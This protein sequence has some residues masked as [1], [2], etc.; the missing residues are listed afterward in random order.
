MVVKK[1]LKN[2]KG[3]RKAQRKRR[4]ARLKTR[5]PKQEEKVLLIDGNYSYYPVA[6]CKFHKAF[7]TQGL[8]EVHRCP[9]RKCPRFRKVVQNEKVKNPPS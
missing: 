2:N 3:N 7:L 5:P 8:M 4:K 6:F 1:T 9:Q